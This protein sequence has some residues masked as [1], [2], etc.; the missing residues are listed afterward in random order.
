MSSQDWWKP[1]N[2]PTDESYPHNGSNV[3]AIFSPEA[4]VTSVIVEERWGR[5]ENIQLAFGVKEDISNLDLSFILNEDGGPI[6][7]G[8]TGSK[9]YLPVDTPDVSLLAVYIVNP[10]PT[11]Y[12][13]S[14][15]GCVG[16]Y[17]CTCLHIILT[18]FT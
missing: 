2:P 4:K 11:L 12:R 10:N 17:T 9:I 16:K 8:Y 1:I 3:I 14:F 15:R 5:K 7:D 18:S 13:F 6:F